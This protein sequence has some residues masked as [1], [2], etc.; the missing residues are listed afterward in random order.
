PY[1]RFGDINNIIEDQHGAIWIGS[2]D[3]GVARFDLQ[4]QQFNTW[5]QHAGSE[6]GL[7]MNGI[8][9]ILE[10]AN[11]QLWLRAGNINHRVLFDVEAPAQ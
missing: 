3:Q 4:K 5:L 6:H 9:L 1:L 10:D 8:Q 11:K 7:Q 2:T